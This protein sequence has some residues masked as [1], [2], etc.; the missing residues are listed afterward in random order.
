M[1]N[2]LH[3]AGAQ[4]ILEIYI[5]ASNIH[6]Y[7]QSLSF[8]LD[9]PVVVIDPT[10]TII[11]HSDIKDID[12][13]LW[14]TGILNGHYTDQIIEEIIEKH[15]QRDLKIN[16]NQ[17][18]IRENVPSKYKRIISNLCLK[19]SVYGSL[20][21]LHMNGIQEEIEDILPLASD[22][23]LKFLNFD[24]T[25]TAINMLNDN[26]AYYEM[27]FMNL[28]L[29]NIQE[30]DMSANRVIGMLQE[31]ARYFQLL[32]VP[33][34]EFNKIAVR[35]LKK[36]L[37]SLIHNTWVIYFKNY[38]HVLRMANTIF[39]DDENKL[40]EIRSILRDFSARVCY[41]ETFTNIFHVPKH[42][43][44]N[45]RA[46]DLSERLKSENKIVNYEN[47]I[48]LDLAMTAVKN[49]SQSLEDFVT[50]KIRLIRK[51][52]RQHQTNFFETFYVFLQTKESYA[53]TAKILM[54][55]R[56]TVY[57][58]INRIKDYFSIDISS[59]ESYSAMLI[60][61][62]VAHYKDLLDQ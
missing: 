15:R 4:S 25:D 5:K 47:Y 45:L 39:A 59:F 12:D 37:E 48:F 35:N 42:Y 49:E 28:L 22:L 57:Y 21:V 51:Y 30:T 50:T 24:K 19:G 11:S 33:I 36:N 55:H 58:R 27:I 54:T 61:C 17:P 62:I 20:V 14:T 18:Y 8:L 13:S 29:G 1:V 2:M 26:S 41:S 16:N 43:Q 6:E 60:S 44:R 40:V 7:I 3:S 56:N 38:I 9:N 23:T 31:S 46:L 52:D 32:S 53:Q 10:F 34:V